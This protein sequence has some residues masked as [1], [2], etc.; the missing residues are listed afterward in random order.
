LLHSYLSATNGSTFVARR[1]GIQEA[2]NPIKTNNNEIAAYVMGSVA[3]IPNTD[4]SF[5]LP[6]EAGIG[7]ASK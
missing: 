1:A 6:L 5:F 4:P 7:G 3:L 2:N